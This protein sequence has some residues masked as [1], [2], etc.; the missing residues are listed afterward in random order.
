MT[1]TIRPAVE[2]DYDDVRRITRTAYLHGGYVSDEDPYLE[3]LDNV[4][5]RAHH[6][7]VWVAELD[8][9]VVGAVALTLPGQAYADIAQAGELEFRMLAVDPAAQGSGVGRA[10]VQ[11]IISYARS[12]DGVDAVSLTSGDDMTRAHALYRSF[13]FVRVPERDWS[14]PGYREQL[15]VFRLD[16]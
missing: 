13:G 3:I 6:A 15:R 7:T 2:R 9:R 14:V 16:L 12:L 10:M 11:E 8:G 4:E 5:H 1:I